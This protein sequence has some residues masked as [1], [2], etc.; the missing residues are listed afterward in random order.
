MSKTKEKYM[1]YAYTS[2][3]QNE[4]NSIGVNKEDGDEQSK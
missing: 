1:V 2:H 4:G 3:V